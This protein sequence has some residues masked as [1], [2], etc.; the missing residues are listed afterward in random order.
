M[1][2]YLAKPIRANLLIQK[3][4]ECLK[5]KNIQRRSVETPAVA[6]EVPAFDPEVIRSLQE[7]VGKEMLLSVYEDFEAE[8]RE[9]IQQVK[10][11]F[12]RKDVVSIQKEL[13]TL[14]GNSGTIGLMRIHEITRAI[15]VPA[16]DGILDGFE[17]KMAAL[18]KEFNYFLQEYPKKTQE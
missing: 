3:V 1:D 7:M 5:G 4:E 15:E 12:I 11:A 17:E 18:E 2:N 10:E 14:K 6:V 8:A 9:Q 16:K 13:H